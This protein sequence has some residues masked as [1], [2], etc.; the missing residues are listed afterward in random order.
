MKMKI[1]V[2]IAGI[3][4]AVVPA[5]AHHSFAAEFDSSKTL[6]LKGT[7]T[8]LE[9]INPHARFYVDVKDESGNITN[10]ELELG[11]PNSLM[12]QGWNRNSLKPGDVI[13]VEAYVAK[14]ASKLANAHQV[15]LANGKKVFAGSTYDEGG[16]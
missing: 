12:R 13:T 7:V 10:W 3:L 4:A 15:S 2:L 5:V 8:K 11:S 14:D 6:T 1:A 16:K 9:W